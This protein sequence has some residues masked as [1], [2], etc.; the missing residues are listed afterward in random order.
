MRRLRRGSSSGSD[1]GGSCAKEVRRGRDDGGLA[2]DEE[3][4]EG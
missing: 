4:K 1:N 2:L 3:K